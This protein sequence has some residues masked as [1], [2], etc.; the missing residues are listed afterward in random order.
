MPKFTSKYNRYQSGLGLDSH[1][2]WRTIQGYK[3]KG[4]VFYFSLR[5]QIDEGKITKAQGKEV[6]KG[7]LK[8]LRAEP[9][10]M[11][12]EIRATQE[13]RRLYNRWLKGWRESYGCYVN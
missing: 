12:W 9:E 4:M 5:A 7:V 2:Q 8:R 3:T 13:G 10:D 11:E 6:I 1:K